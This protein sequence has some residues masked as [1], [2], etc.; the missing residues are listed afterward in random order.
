MIEKIDVTKN[1]TVRG[2][3]LANM[4]LVIEDMIRNPTAYREINVEYEFR[5][6]LDHGEI[7]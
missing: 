1:Y 7:Q 3:D 5:S 6:I 2:V 4:E